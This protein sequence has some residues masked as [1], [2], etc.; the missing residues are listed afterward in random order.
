MTSLC[1]AR[2]LHG[3]ARARRADE[4]DRGRGEG[5]ARTSPV[6]AQVAERGDPAHRSNRQ[7]AGERGAVR[8]AT[9]PDGHGAREHRVRHA[10]AVLGRPP[11][12]SR[13]AASTFPC[14]SASDPSKETPAAL[15]W[16][17]PPT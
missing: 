11:R 1:R 16:P 9:Q 15:A 4:A 5:V 14:T 8:V 13:A 17:P 6:D 2:L 7:R 3:E 10:G 12:Y